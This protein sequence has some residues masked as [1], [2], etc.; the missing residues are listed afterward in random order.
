MEMEPWSDEELLATMGKFPGV[1]SDADLDELDR[2][3]AGVSRLVGKRRVILYDSGNGTEGQSEKLSVFVL[4]PSGAPAPM[5][6]RCKR[7]PMLDRGLEQ[8]E[9]RIW[10]VSHVVSVGSWLEADFADEDALFKFV[11][12]DLMSGGIPT[13]LYDPRRPVPELRFYPNGLAD[14]E[15]YEVLNV[16]FTSISVATIFEKIDL[17]HEKGLVAPSAFSGVSVW[18]NAS[19]GMP[20][21]NAEVVLG[22]LLT[23]GLQQAFPTC[24]VRTEQTGPTGRLDIEIEEPV[25]SKPGVFVRHAILE[26]KVIRGF[27]SQGN[28][29]TDSAVKRHIRDGINQAAAYCSDRGAGLAALCCF[30]LRREYSGQGCFS[31]VQVHARS[32]GVHLRSW[33]LF[34]SAKDYRNYLDRSGQLALPALT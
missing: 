7:S 30:D 6:D 12:V 33:H 16:A 29:V 10:F 14:V 20:V 11:T 32:V 24:T 31:S 15:N 22:A 23:T 17:L 18:R 4:A 2:F 13:V 21:N 26:L 5:G 9:G 8:I 25:F 27:N 3:R 19:R 34:W 1:G 28:A